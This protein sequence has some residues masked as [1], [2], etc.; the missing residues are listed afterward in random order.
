MQL[1]SEVSMPPSVTGPRD[2]YYG[3]V[4]EAV[5]WT[6]DRMLPL[7]LEGSMWERPVPDTHLMRGR[8]P[9]ANRIRKRHLSV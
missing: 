6:I 1:K 2:Q 3:H 8:P 4:I 7:G 9:N 5:D